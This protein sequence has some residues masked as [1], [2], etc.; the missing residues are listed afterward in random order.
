[1]NESAILWVMAVLI[2]AVGLATSGCTTAPTNTAR[3]P[4]IP[5]HSDTNLFPAGTIAPTSSEVS[6][7][8]SDN[9]S[10]K[11]TGTTTVE[12]RARR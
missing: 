10:I 9:T 5:S 6:P 2:A 8:I 1:M 11:G 3:L 7:A 12:P 4:P